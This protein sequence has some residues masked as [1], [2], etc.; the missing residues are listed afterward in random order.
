[1]SLDTIYLNQTLNQLEEVALTIRRNPVEQTETGVILNVSETRLQ[2][3]PN[4]LSILNFAPNIST[5]NGL[6]ILGSDDILVQLDGKDI[7]I[8]K[9]RISTFLETI[10]PKI[11]ES[12]EVIDRVDGS[13]EGDKSGI[14]KITTIKKDG[15]NGNISQNISY[16]QEFGYTTD[17]GLFYKREQLRVF[18]NYYHSRHKTIANG[19]A[20]QTRN[21]NEILYKNTENGKLNRKNDYLTFGVDYDL[22][23]DNSLS[24]LYIFEDDQ[25]DNHRRT[26]S[27]KISGNNISPD[28]LVT[29]KTYFDQIN[30][31][32]SFSLNF[33]SDLDSLGSNLSVALDFAKKKYLNP[34]YQVNSFKN[35]I[36]FIQE[37]NQQN[38]NSNNDIYAFNTT[39]KKKFTSKKE[40]SLGTRVSL[41]DNK[42]HF[43]FLDLQG[44]QWITNTNFSN[45]FFLKEYIVSGFSTFST[46][47]NQKSKISLGVRAEYNYND[48][49]NGITE[50]DN[51]NFRL[52]PNALYSTKLFGNSFYISALQRMSRPNYYLFNP[53]YIKSNP[54]NAYSGN[55][56]LKPIDI[57]RLQTGYIFKNN[58]RLDLRYNY[59]ENNVMSIPINDNGILTTSPINIG[60]RNDLFAFVS[61]PYKI[62]DW[63]EIFTSINVA[64]F[65]FKLSDQ[66]FNSYYGTF[67]LNNTF[68]LPLDI[69]ANVYYY[70]TSDYR[71]LYHK[72]KETNS[73]NINIFYPI[74][75][76]FS[77]RGVINDVFNSLRTR[78]E[79][80]FNQIYNYSFNRNNS[81]SFS[82]SITYKFTKGKEMDDDVRDAGID[83]IKERF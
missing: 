22:N 25:D 14:I 51:N 79:Y 18:G 56:N 17:A 35:N 7:R 12:I 66:K 28:S 61:F 31:M 40:F 32:H 4:L 50:G 42:D 65:D 3:L 78:N 47:I 60:Y 81:L 64:Y 9:S 29:S 71:I 53:T 23:Q 2:N 55:E 39:W 44:G 70:Y 26:L 77:L 15:W 13:L 24:F 37:E 38:S 19:Y 72:N 58:F 27:S 74:S 49:T 45:D 30:K 41:V 48:Y 1:L 5:S 54:T 80:N 21:N 43:H 16:N 76:S 11:I 52:L 57:Y 73:L 8:D 10:N 36:D 59:T 83:D 33:N 67:S 46:P 68:Y 63:W 75:E 62:G 6:K 34:F 69:E 20:T 82:L